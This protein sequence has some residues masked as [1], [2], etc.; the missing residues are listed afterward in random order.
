MEAGRP[1]T[2][3]PPPIDLRCEQAVGPFID[4]REPGLSWKLDDSRQGAAQTAYRVLVASSPE[5]LNHDEGDLWDSGKVGSDEC[6][7]VPYQGQ[8][9]QSGQR[10]WWKVKVWD[11]EGRETPWSEPASWRMALMDGVEWR[12]HWI[13]AP[14]MQE[15]A[16]EGRDAF[17]DAACMTAASRQLFLDRK[18]VLL[19]RRTFP[20]AEGG[21]SDAI[22]RVCGLGAFNLFVNGRRVGEAWL[23][24]I[25]SDYD[26]VAYYRTFEVGEYLHTGDNVVAVEV[27]DGWYGQG[28]VWGGEFG[29]GSP[30]LLAEVE[31]ADRSGQ[32]HFLGTSAGWKVRFAPT[33]RS[34]IYAGEMKDARLEPVGWT[35]PGYDDSVWA[36]AVETKPASRRL[37]SQVAPSIIDIRRIQPVTRSM[38]EPGVYVFDFGEH[39]SGVVRLRVRNAKPGQTVT[40]LCG[41]FCGPDG[42]VDHSLM[43]ACQVRQTMTYVCRGDDVE[44][45]TPAF[46]YFGLR[47]AE[48]TGLHAEPAMDLLE[49][50]FLST[51]MVSAGE[52]E[53]SLGLYN[54]MHRMA[55]QTLQSNIHGIIEDCPHREKCGWLGD[56][57]MPIQTWLYNGNLGAFNRKFIEDIRLCYQP[58]GLPADIAGGKRRHPWTEKRAAMLDWMAATIIH[59]YQHYIF[60]A[61]RPELERHYPFMTRFADTAVPLIR[62]RYASGRLDLIRT[63]RFFFGDWGDVTVD[64]KRAGDFHLFPA[65]TPA[66]LSGTQTLIYAL[67]CLVASAQVMGNQAD[68]ERFAAMEAELVRLANSTYF[69]ATTASYGSQ[70][71][72]AWAFKLGMVPEDSHE[73]FVRRFGEEI[74]AVDQLVPT[75]GQMGL[76]TIFQSLTDAGHGPMVHALAD[77]KANRGFRRLIERGATTLWESQGRGEPVPTESGNHPAFSGYD[78]W[79]YSHLCGIRPDPAQPGFKRTLLKPWFDPTVEWARAAHN[80]PYGLICSEWKRQPGGTIEWIVVVPPN[81]TA[82]AET[83]ETLKFDDNTNLRELT[84]GRHTMR[85][86]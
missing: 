79:F 85:L 40:V 27:A 68:Q 24:P 1:E 22:V 26:K 73:A 46:T 61:D 47:Y 77:A 35:K 62:E 18:P 41:D 4:V 6:V 50:V 44:E 58:G 8:R 11:H 37:A 74:S 21:A 55:V 2:L 54:A 80:S 82:L 52:F 57:W 9:L 72:N 23:D 38:P 19:F 71:A 51:E 33:L 76:V 15:P 20:V 7:L 42:R 66:A 28:V 43:E 67:Q 65:A 14:T 30:K 75:Y 48:V 84:S 32:T 56:A 34:N 45:W 5:R 10:V 3:L 86:G 53:C 17:L 78:A 69:D 39:F 25:S 70:A 81:T 16:S 36:E 64:G 31:W 63:D 29:Y 83:P 60:T 59:P 49:G 13:A 12:A